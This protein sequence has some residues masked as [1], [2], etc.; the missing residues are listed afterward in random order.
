MEGMLNWLLSIQLAFGPL[1]M[2]SELVRISSSPP[3]VID[4]SAIEVREIEVNVS[5]VSSVFDECAG[6]LLAPTAQLLVVLPTLNEPLD[7]VVMGYLDLL[8]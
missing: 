1:V 3:Q 5:I 2:A 4:L 8:D 6:I 7:L